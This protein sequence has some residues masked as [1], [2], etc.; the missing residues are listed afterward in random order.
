MIA[1]KFM[2]KKP[3]INALLAIIY[4]ALV[5]SIMFYAQD[6]GAPQED[7]VLMPI[8][9]IS[10]FTF[11]A[12]VMG[13]LFLSEPV[14]LYLDGKKKEAVNFFLKTLVTFGVITVLALSAMIFNIFG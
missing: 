5:A 12:G 9:L 10:L 4:I 2:T 7:N 1:S 11:S 13:Y 3:Y 6:L 8:A 14:Q